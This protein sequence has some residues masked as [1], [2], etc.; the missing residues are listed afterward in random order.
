MTDAG[1]VDRT[2]PEWTQA[3][4]REVGYMLCDC[5]HLIQSHS[6]YETTTMCRCCPCPRVRPP[7]LAL[8]Q[9]DREYRRRIAHRVVLAL[10]EEA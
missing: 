2:D 10:T 3:A 7:D 1:T 6:V 8:L 5:A 4:R 9:I